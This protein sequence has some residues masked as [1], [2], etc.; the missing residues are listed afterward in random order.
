MTRDTSGT[1]VTAFGLGTH[2][3]LG[4]ALARLIIKVVLE[5]L[6]AAVADYEVDESS[7]RFVRSPGVRGVRELI[8]TLVPR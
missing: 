1:V 2:F 7:V 3:C 8:T 6:V 4:A 5:E